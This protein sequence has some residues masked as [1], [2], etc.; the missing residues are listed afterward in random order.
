M[1]EMQGTIECANVDGGFR[2][3]LGFKLCR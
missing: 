3:I 1:Q 2:V